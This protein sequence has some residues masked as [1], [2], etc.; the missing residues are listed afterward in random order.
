MRMT[1]ENLIEIGVGQ[2]GGA[3]VYAPLR[4]GIERIASSGGE[5]IKTDYYLE[6]GGFARHDVVCLSPRIRV[7]GRRITGD[8]AQDYIASL[9]FA[10]GERRKTRLRV[11]R[12]GETAECGCVIAEISDMGGSAM[13]ADGFSCIL[14]L[15]GKPTVK[16]EE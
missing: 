3:W 9:R 2:T 4:R 14:L 12:G 8:A 16:G 10:A 15:D 1:R 13:E 7:S 11:R 5:K 6:D